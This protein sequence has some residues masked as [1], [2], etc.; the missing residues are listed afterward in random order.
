[1]ITFSFKLLKILT[2]QA[3]AAPYSIYEGVDVEPL[4]LKNIW[5]GNL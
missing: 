3:V 2:E 5:T 4:G 1:L